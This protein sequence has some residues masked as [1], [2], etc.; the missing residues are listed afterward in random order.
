M[1]SL[2]ATNFLATTVFFVVLDI[3]AVACR[4]CSRLSRRHP[5][6]VDDWICIPA[7]AV[8]LGCA[9][10]LIYGMMFPL[11]VRGRCVL[12]T[13]FH[14][15]ISEK[16]V[17]YHTEPPTSMQ[18]MIA[19]EESGI[20]MAKVC[21]VSHRRRVLRMVSRLGTMLLIVPSGFCIFF[22]DLLRGHH[23]H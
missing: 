12:T 9:A 10:L 5:V 2:N 17:G 16:I 19:L 8:V 13:G 4:F 6:G 20:L 21:L 18:Q 15:G 23:S 1:S 11:E 3:S 22:D 7:L 14:Q